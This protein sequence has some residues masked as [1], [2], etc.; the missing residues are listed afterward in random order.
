M[1][2]YFCGEEAA[3]AK[4]EEAAEAGADNG[5]HRLRF[6]DAGLSSGS[7]SRVLFK[8]APQAMARSGQG[9]SERG[10]AV[11]AAAA[12]PAQRR[13]PRCLEWAGGKGRERRGRLRQGRLRRLPAGLSLGSG[14]GS[15]SSSPGSVQLDLR[16]PRPLRPARPG[17]I[18]PAA[19]GG[20]RVEPRGA[21][22]VPGARCG[23][24]DAGRWRGP[25][26]GDGGGDGAPGRNPRTSNMASTTTPPVQTPAPPAAE[27][28]GTRG[29]PAPALSAQRQEGHC[30]AWTT[31]PG[32]RR[33]SRVGFRVLV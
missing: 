22:L 23:A 18:P 6:G 1:R 20:A 17:Q 2:R 33:A 32:V 7:K 24:A 10:A 21:V 26:G 28:H 15:G 16:S 30:G 12:G 5:A 25:G 27:A 8:V 11:K 9:G 14:L 19:G 3:A 29:F 31:T 13:L 4:E